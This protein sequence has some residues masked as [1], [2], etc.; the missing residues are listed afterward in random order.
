MRNKLHFA[1]YLTTV[2]FV[3]TIFACGKAREEKADIPVEIEEMSPPPVNE[4]DAVSDHMPNDSELEE[5]FNADTLNEEQLR[6]FQK[7]AQQ[8]L[9]DF[10]NYIEI[11]SNKRYNSQLRLAACQQIE[12]LFADSSVII[13]IRFDQIEKDPRTASLFIK[14]V[15]NSGYDSIKIKTN[16]VIV[17]PAEK[18]NETLEYVGNITADVTII[19]YK[20][21]TIAFYSKGIHKAKT[22]IHKQEK[23]F[24]KDSQTLWS[25]FIGELN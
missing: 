10:I 8:K 3:C 24:G 25:V 13:D 18:L 16:S 14:D 6:I 11:I 4:T 7:R 23:Q 15:Y 1:L 9:Q 20:K 22:I 21:S 12:E 17:N 5:S 19:G 2:V